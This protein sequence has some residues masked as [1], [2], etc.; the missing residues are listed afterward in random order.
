MFTLANWGGYTLTAH[1]MGRLYGTAYAFSM[2]ETLQTSLPSGNTFN[3]TFSGSAQA[4]IFYVNLT[5]SGPLQMALNGIP[6][7]SR[8]ELYAKLGALPTR[9]DYDYSSLN[10][11]AGTLQ[12][13][14]SLAPAGTWYFLVYAD[15]VPVSGAYTLAPT[16]SSLILTAETP[17]RH[18][19]NVDATLTLT[20]AGFDAAT[21]VELVASNGTAY[22]A[23]SVG[24]YL[25]T[26]ITATFAAN[27][28]PAGTYTVRVRRAGGDSSALPNALQVISGGQARLVTN[29]IVPSTV[30]RHAPATIYIEYANQGTVAMP[31]PLLVLTGTQRPILTVI[32]MGLMFTE[33][34]WTSAMPSGFST[35]IQILAMGGTPRCA[36]AR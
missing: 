3:G 25:F 18:G 14:V 36:P 4:Q 6:A 11:S 16:S 5:N 23:S 32:R 12:L 8:I 10:P 21:L 30:G 26:Q 34:F 31:A 33:G 27:T 24:V 20:G 7:W 2:D 13:L 9:A 22:A 28:I 17:D 29:L 1:G 35:N 19:N 15:Y